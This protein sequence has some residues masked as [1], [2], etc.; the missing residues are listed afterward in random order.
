MSPLRDEEEVALGDADDAVGEAKDR[1]ESLHLGIM[2]GQEDSFIQWATRY[3]PA[4]RRR[5]IELGLSETDAETASDDAVVAACLAAGD[6][7]PLGAGLRKYAYGVLRKKVADC[8]RRGHLAQATVALQDV[9][10]LEEPLQSDESDTASPS[11]VSRQ[12]LARLVQQCLESLRDS[13]RELIE[14]VSIEHVPRDVVATQRGIA[15]NSVTQALARAL[16][17]VRRCIEEGA[18]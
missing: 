13:D 14:L 15:V 7:R 17:R 2:A 5:A 10:E 8:Q 12:P 18:T 11:G 16:N 3:G 9:P 4:F 6:L 1:D